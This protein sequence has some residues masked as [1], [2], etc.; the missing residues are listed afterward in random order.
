MRVHVFRNMGEI[1][2]SPNCC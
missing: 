2:K 1:K